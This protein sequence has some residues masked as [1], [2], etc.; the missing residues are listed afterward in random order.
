MGSDKPELPF[1]DIAPK[2]AALTEDMLLGDI[3]ERPGLLPRDRSLITLATLMS[4]YRL[5]QLEFHIERA[6]ENGVT[7]E[8][9]VELVT[10]IAFY[11]GW[12]ASMS[13]IMR[14]RQALAGRKA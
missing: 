9:M 3:W 7:G 2:L 1:K 10:H 14:V 13:A 12:P 6:F 5:E 8:E 4:L 11:A